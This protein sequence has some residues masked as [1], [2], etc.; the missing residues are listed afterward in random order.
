MGEGREGGREERRVCGAREERETTGWSQGNAILQYHAR[1]DRGK[2]K[3]RE[4]GLLIR[5][6]V[7]GF[8]KGRIPKRCIRYMH[9]QGRRK[10]REHPS[11]YQQ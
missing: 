2:N 5:V 1:R 10:K 8:T 6:M 11:D 7:S 3:E 4:A 9:R